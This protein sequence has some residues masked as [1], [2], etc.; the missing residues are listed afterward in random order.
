MESKVKKLF[1]KR[2]E[3]LGLVAVALNNLRIKGLADY[4][5]LF[6]EGKAVFFELKDD[7]AKPNRKHDEEQ[8]ESAAA[9]QNQGFDVFFLQGKEQVEKF[10]KV[11]GGAM[12]YLR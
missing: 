2:C 12:Q 11:G 7:D 3:D 9:L 8:A 4:M 6:P 5:V 10:F 1:R